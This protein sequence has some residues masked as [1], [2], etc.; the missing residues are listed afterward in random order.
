MFPCLVIIQDDRLARQCYLAGKTFAHRQTNPNIPIQT[1]GLCQAQGILVLL[2]KIDKA[3]SR[4]HQGNGMRKNA[5]K[6]FRDTGQI[7]QVVGSFIKRLKDI[8]AIL[9]F[10]K[11]FSFGHCQWN[12]SDSLL[13]GENFFS[14][15]YTWGMHNDQGKA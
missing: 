6:Q 12:L 8:G 3:T 1:L 14:R 15:K 7:G 5:G 4:S 13:A 9:D 2:K 11:Q 10:L